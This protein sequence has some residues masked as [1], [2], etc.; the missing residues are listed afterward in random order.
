MDPKP[1]NKTTEF[2][3]TIIQAAAGLLLTFA[4]SQG[5]IVAD[6]VDTAQVQGQIAEVYDEA[7][8]GDDDVRALIN[9]VLGLAGLIVSGLAVGGYNK[10]RLAVKVANAGAATEDPETTDED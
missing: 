5:W 7:S 3:L 4:A 8:D 1:G 9:G 6:D 10:G 2:V